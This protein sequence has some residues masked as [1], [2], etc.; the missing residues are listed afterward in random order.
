MNVE[1]RPDRFT[2]RKEYFGG[3]IYDAAKARIELL[4]SPEH[5][6]I[7]RLAL[8]EEQIF[9]TQLKANPE[10]AQRLKVFQKAGFVNVHDD[11]RLSLTSVRVVPDLEPM[12]DGMLTAP[13]RVFDSITQFCN[14]ECPQCY[15]SSSN[16]VKETRRTLKQTVDIMQKFASA[17]TM[18]WRV[19]GGEPTTDPNLFD[20]L[21]AGKR[22][23][24]NVGLY[25]NGWWSEST[26]Q[27]I[28]DAGLDEIVISV[29]GRPEVND[30]RRKAGAFARA[31]KS[32]EK[33]REYNGGRNDNRIN[34]VIAAAIGRDNVGEVE[35]LVKLAMQYGVDVNFMPLKP[36]GR[37]RNELTDTHL[38]PSEYMQFAKRIQQIREIQEV[39]DSGIKVI[40]KYKDLFCGDYPNRSGLPF[41]FDYS[42]CAAL[43][44]AI[45]MIPDGRV[46]SC[47]F[48]LDVDPSEEFM[49]P[50]MVN[51]SVYEAWFNPNFK[52]Y[53]QAAKAGCEDCGFYKKQC[54][55]SCRATV[56]GNGGKV[57][58]GKLIGND[59]QCF[60]PI[61]PTNS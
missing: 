36:S 31:V 41:P 37:A 56:L 33:I 3:L 34:G 18:E 57:V 22:L 4:Q 10:L 51:V 27:K 30:K 38:V 7:A 28:L 61:I 6:L 43:T 32:L 42:E 59:P 16:Q 50:N 8:A 1:N 40:L 23:G 5:A 12:P 49:G 44:T 55:G 48:V 45:S 35:F 17:G 24:M 53:R 9:E 25:T 15:F 47:P 29:E 13:I 11:G 14:F 58:D 52:N 2:L 54:R 46:Y 39:K 20:I 19:T 21:S 26:S 60:A